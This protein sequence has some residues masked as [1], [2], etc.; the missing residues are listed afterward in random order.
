[1]APATTDGPIATDLPVAMDAPALMDAPG[2]IDPPVAV[3]VHIALDT[4][5]PI[6]PTAAI[7][8][9]TPVAAPGPVNRP[10]VSESHATGHVLPLSAPER[11]LGGEVN[12]DIATRL[13]AEVLAL[14]LGNLTPIRA[15]TLL[16]ELQKEARDAVPWSSW[17]AEIAGARE[18]SEER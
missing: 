18:R 15:L 1:M 10:A 9:P 14:D 13:L 12:P 5:S 2:A 4:L 16:H 6:A 17:M 8:A 11:G 3:D 7:D